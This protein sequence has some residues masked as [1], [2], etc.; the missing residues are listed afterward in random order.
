MSDSC[1]ICIFLLL[2]NITGNHLHNCKD[3][4]PYSSCYLKLGN[5]SSK[6]NACLF[7]NEKTHLWEFH[8]EVPS[9][10]MDVKLTTIMSESE[11]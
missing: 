8:R 11:G 1:K 9:S 3:L 2:S 4:I 10:M 6:R 7:I 5:V